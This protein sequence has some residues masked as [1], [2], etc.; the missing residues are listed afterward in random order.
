MT[1]EQQAVLAS[2]IAAAISA[3]AAAVTAVVATVALVIQHRAGRSRVKV[4]H[5]MAWYTLG[6][7]MSDPWLTIVPLSPEAEQWS[8]T[9]EWTSQTAEHMNLDDEA[10][11]QLLHEVPG[12]AGSPLPPAGA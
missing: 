2:A 11:I 7:A 1:P 3:L 8:A 9:E 12:C 6:S 5:Q 4:R 10:L